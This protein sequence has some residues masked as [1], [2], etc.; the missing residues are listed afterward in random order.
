MISGLLSYVFP[1]LLIVFLPMLQDFY[2]T[3]RWI[4]LTAATILVLVAWGVQLLKTKKMDTAMPPIALGFGALTIASI[5]S[6]L[7]ASTNKIEGVVHPLGPVTYGCLFFITLLLPQLLSKEQKKRVLWLA[8]AAIGLLGLIVVYQQFAIAS[9]MFPQASY[10]ASNLW[11]PTG[12]PISAGLLF[13]LGLPLAVGLT[14][15]GF[16]QHKERHAAFALVCSILMVVGCGIT[17]WRFLPLIPMVVMPILIGWATLLE[18][19]KT[20]KTAV[21]GVGAENFLSAY[22][23]A[24]PVSVNQTALWNTGFSTSATLWLHIATTMGLIGAAACGAFLAAWIRTMPKQ[25]EL[26]IFWGLAVL[27]LLVFPPSVVFLLFIALVSVAVD[28]APQQPQAVSRSGALGIA[29]GIFL[30]AAASLVGLYR[31]ANGEYLYTQARSAAETENNVTR[32]YNY[33]ILAI[34]QNPFMTRYHLSLSQLALIMGGSILGQAPKNDETGLV[35]LLDDDKTLVTSLFGLAVSEAKQGV[36]L[37]P[38]NYV[39]WTNL[40]TVYQSL[41]GI[42]GDAETWTVAAYQKAI[43]LN[44]VSPTLRVDFGGMY[45][46]AKDYDNAIA[47]FF[48]A[49]AL[50]P[51]FANGYYNL[52]N[53]YKAKGDIPQATSALVQTRTLLPKDGTDYAKVSEELTALQGQTPGESIP[54]TIPSGTP[55]KP[56]PTRMPL[57]LP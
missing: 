50:K 44:P 52:A 53:A 14:R 8:V 31:F 48:T 11:N 29:I 18:A 57:I 6:I 51:N 37:A 25:W 22:A 3:G 1:F 15:E 16:Q 4:L 43:T 7:A 27:A 47:Q 33:H 56:T 9:I 42:A 38:T 54:A 24:K 55:D 45:M 36:S 19:Y 5:V 49:V 20:G 10:L 39:A 12:T 13:L 28:H 34:K 46:N 41:I 2:D 30:A 40:A 35:T 32:S 26:R 23:L 21:A 17:L